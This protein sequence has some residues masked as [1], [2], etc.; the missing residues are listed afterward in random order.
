MFA[1]DIGAGID[2]FKAIDARLVDVGRFR[3][4]RA[5]QPA[6][7][8]G[9]QCAVVVGIQEDGHAGQTWFVR[10]SDTVGI[11]IVPRDAAKFG[12]MD[13]DASEID[14]GQHVAHRDTD[15]CLNAHI[16]QGEEWILNDI[17]LRLA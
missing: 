3:I 5:R 1:N 13:L 16:I 2:V 15:E 9:V 10:F 4:I 8:P 7:L 17:Q 14:T 11:A 6:D 12:G